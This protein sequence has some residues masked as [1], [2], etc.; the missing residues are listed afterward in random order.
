MLMGRIRYI[1]LTFVFNCSVSISISV[2]VSV[3]A[4]VQECEVSEQLPYVKPEHETIVAHF[5]NSSPEIFL[6]Q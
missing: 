4:R 1:L 5:W 2:S 3:M 6:R